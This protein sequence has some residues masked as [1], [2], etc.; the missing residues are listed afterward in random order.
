MK[1]ISEL[2]ESHTIRLHHL[3]V[4]PVDTTGVESTS[5]MNIHTRCVKKTNLAPQGLS[6]LPRGSV[7]RKTAVGFGLLQVEWQL[8]VLSVERRGVS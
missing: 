6:F 3:Q 8:L 7:D 5:L 1:T 2:K 4:T